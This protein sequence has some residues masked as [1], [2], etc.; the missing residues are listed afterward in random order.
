M[1]LFEQRETNLNCKLEFLLKKKKLV[2]TILKSTE[3]MS[4]KT[5]LICNICKMILK[6]PVSLPCLSTVCGDHLRDDA[7]K[8]DMFKCLTCNKDFEIA[9]KEITPNKI[10]A[11]MLV[12]ELHLTDIERA[13]KHAILDLIQQLEVLQSVLMVKLN[14]MNLA[15]TEIKKMNSLQREKPTDKIKSL[16]MLDQVNKKE[17]FYNSKI[18]ESSLAMKTVDIQQSKQILEDEFRKPDLLIEDVTRFRNEHEQK[19][20][21]FQARINELDSLVKEITKSLEFNELQK[22]ELIACTSGNTIKIF[23]MVSNERVTTLDEHSKVV[24][25]LENI[26]ENRFASGSYDRTIKIWDAKNF[27]CL[28]TVETCHQDVIWCLKMLNSNRIASGSDKEIKI[29]DIESGRCMQTL[30]GHSGSIYGIICLPNGNLV[31]CSD[32]TT[33]KVW[34][35]SKENFLKTL[36]SHSSFVSC[37]LLLKNGHLASGS[38]DKTI[39][40]WNMTSSVCIKTLHGHS[41][42][43]MRLQELNIGELISCSRDKTIKIWNLNEGSCIQTLLGHTGWVNSIRINNQNSDLVSFSSD[44]TI[45]TWD[46][47]TGEC[48]KSIDVQSGDDI[49]DLIFI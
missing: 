5:S 15:I 39:K 46:L 35:L 24:T 8:N 13:I 43:V 27:A 17:K 48:V 40:I 42:E 33:I 16:Q 41:S 32:D 38:W 12:K 22:D 29:W 45:K 31:S 2:F 49:Q 34:D 25:C 28:K 21:E 44:G 18:A 19:V 30:N 9:N 11:T 26:D 23:N 36:R 14:D 10:K 6:D 20:N 4:L 37:L 1:L 3:N 47:K 7:A